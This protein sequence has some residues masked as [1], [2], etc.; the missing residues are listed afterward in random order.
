MFGLSLG[1]AYLAPHLFDLPGGLEREAFWCI[2]MVGSSSA[3]QFALQ[4]FTSVFTATQR[5]D[6]ANAIGVATRLMTAAG[7]VVALEK[8]QGLIGVS[9]ATCLVSV[10]DYVIRWRVARVLAPLVR[11]SLRQASWARIKEISSFGAWNFLASINTYVYAN[12]PSILIGSFMP[13]AAVGHY[14]LATGLTRQINSLLGP[15][16]QVIY[17]AATERHVQGDRDGLQRLYHN[18]SRLM[19]MVLSSI[20]L[21]AA[22]WA[23][24]FYRLWIGGR[25]LSGG[26]YQSV[27]LLFRI[28]LISVVTDNSSSIAGQVLVGAGYVRAVSTALIVGSVLNLTGSFLL[29]PHLGLAGVATATVIASVVVDLFVMPILAQRLLNLSVASFLRQACARP[30]AVAA[31]QAALFAAVRLSGRPENW[32]QLVAQGAVA[33]AISLVVL[34]G[35]GVNAGERQRFVVQPLRRL[36]RGLGVPL[37]DAASS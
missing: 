26:P 37:A 18:G 12:V 34:I 36:R 11:L 19:L 28:L 17:P 10:V 27:S 31:L 13:I 15:I 29:I 23:D 9:A 25:Y 33:G 7:I 21:V 22:F 35:V 5:F 16:G 30:A 3:I 24:D 6:L 32:F 8:G 20:V 1:A 14:A 4:P 2:L